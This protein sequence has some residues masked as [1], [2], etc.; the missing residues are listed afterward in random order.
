MPFASRDT[1]RGSMAEPEDIAWGTTQRSCPHYFLTISP[2]S[3][4]PEP[5][6]QLSGDGM[7]P[8]NCD[9]ESVRFEPGTLIP[10]GLR[11][12]LGIKDQS[13]IWCITKASAE[14]K[15]F[16]CKTSSF[17][18]HSLGSRRLT[19]AF[20]VGGMPHLG[21]PLTEIRAALLPTGQ[22]KAIASNEAFS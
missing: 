3:K 18:P 15:R 22:E 20:A 14:Q 9:A 19:G 4:T 1:A 12:S 13:P 6:L 16:S 5:K 2:S 7:E 8:V 10:A 11:G 21:L 17:L